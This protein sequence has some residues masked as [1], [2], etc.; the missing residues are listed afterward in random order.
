MSRYTGYMKR[1]G[2]FDGK[3]QF[4]AL[5]DAAERGEGTIITKRGKPVAQIV[6]I[7]LCKPSEAFGMDRGLITITADFDETP[8]EFEE[9]L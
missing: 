2:I 4:S 8:A 3:T 6:P 9:Y 7:S 1:V 5:I